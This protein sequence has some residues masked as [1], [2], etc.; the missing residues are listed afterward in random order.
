M[1]EG[2]KIGIAIAATAVFFLAVAIGWFCWYKKRKRT[3]HSSTIPYA[4]MAAETS[5]PHEVETHERR[6]ELEAKRHPTEGQVYEMGSEYVPPKDWPNKN[7][8]AL[9]TQ[10]N[11]YI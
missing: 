11:G 3:K 8:T 10:K 7:M 2:A 4:E 9:H 6:Q 5:R 1:S